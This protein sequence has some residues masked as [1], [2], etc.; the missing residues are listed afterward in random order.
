MMVILLVMAFAGI[1]DYAY[2]Q[3]GRGKGRLRGHVKDTEGN[4]VA[5]AEVE[6]IFHLD[7]NVKHKTK[8]KKNGRFAFGGLS[9]GNWQIFV[10]AEGY[11]E[12]QTM[13]SIQQVSDNPVAKIILRKPSA[14]VVAKKQLSG[15]S[16]LIGQ[17]KAL[18]EEAKYDEALEKFEKFLAKQPGFFQTYLLIGNCYKEKGEHDVAL[19]K[20][21]TALEKMPADEPD[22]K[23]SAKVNSAIGDLYIR[24]NDLKTAQE[25]FKKSLALDPKDEILAYNVGEIFFSNSKTDE[26][27]HY[28][29]LAS[30]IKPKWSTPYL[31]IGY[32]YLNSADYKNAVASFNK[33]LELD[34]THAEAGTIKELIASLKDM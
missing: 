14:E 32:A 33:F 26:A 6:I 1:S 24:K 25:Y 34:P 9:G 29:K 31:K 8:T 23:L 11:R 17:G 20:Y 28:F 2:A 19:E 27:I 22:I 16:G 15:D 5:N 21:K 7:K 12:A 30:S 13:A 4:N 10:V 18:F 3:A